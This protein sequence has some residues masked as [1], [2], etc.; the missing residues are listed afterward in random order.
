[1]QNSN[2]TLLLREQDYI[3]KTLTTKKERHYVHLLRH[4]IFC[5]EL[6]WR[7]KA[8]NR[9]EIDEYDEVATFFGV[10]NI[11][12]KLLACLRLIPYEAT[13]MLEKDFRLLIDERYRIRKD[14]DT[15]EIS[16][17]CILSEARKY[18]HKI[19][20]RTSMFLYKGVYLWCLKNN[21]K[22]LYLVVEKKIH[23]LLNI[24]GFPCHPVGKP[25]IMADGVT[26]IAAIMNWREFE[27]LNTTANPNMFKWFT[28]FSIFLAL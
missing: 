17:L 25:A 26:A 16:R 15:A 5:E 9:L 1:M 10:F 6:G 11:H 4:K 19:F 21:I 23:R 12:N 20:Q 8:I 7:L 24:K 18:T 14:P 3:V 13:F 27:V 2:S 28:M 22:F